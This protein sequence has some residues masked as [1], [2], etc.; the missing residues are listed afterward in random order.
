MATMTLFH[1]AKKQPEVVSFNRIYQHADVLMLGLVWG[2]Y[3]VAIGVGWAY[4]SLPVALIAG[5]VLAVTSSLI[6]IFFPGKLITRLFYAFTLLG[7][8]ALLIQLGEGETEF[9]FAVFVLLSALL[10]YRD[11]R[12]ILMGAAT[13]AVHHILFNYL[14]EQDLFGV[15]CFMHTGFHMVFFHAIFVVAQSAILIYLAVN[16]ANDARSASEVA[17]LAAQINREAGC[18]TLTKSDRESHSPFAQTFSTALTAMRDTLSKVSAGVADVLNASESII[19]R[20][21]ALSKRTDE[22]ATALA[23]AASAMEQLTCAAELTDEK[24]LEAKILATRTGEIAVRGGESIDKAT[25]TMEQIRDE[26]QRISN[27]L[28]LIDGIAFQTNILSL[29]ASVEAARAGVH[30]KGFAVVASEVRTLAMRCENAAKDIRQLIAVSVE[31][32]RN[33]SLQVEHAGQTMKEVIASIGTLSYLVE[34]LAEMSSQQS[35]NI[36]QMNESVASID[37]SVHENVAHV[38]QTVQAA[39]QQQADELQQAISVFRLA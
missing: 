7:F 35:A 6:N 14:Q 26:S 18:L 34:E 24:S 23:V 39:R 9:H 19:E 4:E 2:L 27:I 12:P 38:A 17:R 32:T 3:V 36:A 1:T 15:I 10:A 29:N 20:N 30:G 28:E 31:C 16:M 13:A 25:H 21:A 37:G 8:A 22:Q 11:Y 33:G 5:A